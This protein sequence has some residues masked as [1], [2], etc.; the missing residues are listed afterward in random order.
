VIRAWVV[1]L[2]CLVTRV[3]SQYMKLSTFMRSC[4]WRSLGPFGYQ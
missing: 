3:T 2:R 1:E 4:G